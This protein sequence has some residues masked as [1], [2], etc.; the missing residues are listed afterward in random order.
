M[1]ADTYNLK[2]YA[3]GC[4]RCY[5]PRALVSEVGGSGKTSKNT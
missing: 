2:G 1:D 3:E 5:D 4:S